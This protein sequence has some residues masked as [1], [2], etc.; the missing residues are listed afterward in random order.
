[1]GLTTLFHAKQTDGSVSFTDANINQQAIME[2][3]T[4]CFDE[5]EVSSTCDSV[6]FYHISNT[7]SM[8]DSE[9]DIETDTESD[10]DS[11]DDEDEE[12][13][14]IYHV[15]EDARRLKLAAKAFSNPEEKVNKY[16]GARCY[17]ER[18]SAPEVVS[19]DEADAQ[20]EVILDV[21]R[22]K[23]LAVDFLVADN[24]VKS[25]DPLSFGRNYFTSCVAADAKEADEVAQVLA[26]T[27][28]LKEQA[29]S[30]LCPEG[31]LKVKS[32]GA[33]CYFDR[34]SAP[35]VASKDE[36]DTEAEVLSD[37]TCMKGLAVD[38]LH[39]ESQTKSTDSFS[40]GRSYFVDPAECKE[41]AD[42]RAQILAEARLLK[43]QAT[44][45]HCPE[46]KV[47]VE[48]IGSRCYF[49][50]AS[51]PEP[52]TR[53]VVDA[54]SEIVLDASR[55]KKLA[56]GFLN[57]ENVSISITASSFGRN[58]FT[59]SAESKE[60]AD[61]RAEALAEAR[62]LKERATNYF[63]PE[64]KVTVESVGSRCYFERASAPETI[65]KGEADAIVE[66]LSDA[67]LIKKLSADFVHPENQ[68]NTTD[69]FSFGRNY[70]TKCSSVPTE[71]KEEVV[72]RAQFIDE[73]TLLKEHAT[74]YLCP[75]LVVTNTDPSTYGRNYFGRLD[76]NEVLSK[77]DADELYGIMSDTGVMKKASTDYL[78]PEVSVSNTHPFAMGRNYFK[79][80][81]SVPTETEEESNERFQILADSVMLKKA[82]VDYLQPEITSTTTDPTAYG[83][84]FFDNYPPEESRKESQLS[85]GNVSNADENNDYFVFDDFDEMREE[86][87]SFNVPKYPT[88][89]HKSFSTN[90]LYDLGTDDVEKERP[91][92]RSPSCVMLFG[93]GNL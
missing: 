32:F 35:E 88:N 52:V 72:K 91:V 47:N 38:F 48:S 44:K 1:M 85:Q 23:N 13:D 77:E 24:E 71:L 51:A 14:E 36:A 27:R 80:L 76:S 42:E 29:A 12:L 37:I 78:R 19:K 69:A 28:M 53:D 70:F 62:L 63:C 57:P 39:P 9:S 41:E 18:A 46:E 5:V 58:Y 3:H 64:K 45:Y 89:V 61:E 86:F 50:R 10:Y 82:A 7:G 93:L 83:R 84:N 54:Q 15:L 56:G 60:E 79:T 25:S 17:F 11:S 75:E 21:T 22:M 33:R 31:D 49:E 74:S 40:F 68:V 92:S 8:T 66:S 59:D 65:T 2:G 30:Y 16:F 90:R 26:E 73:A 4:D 55:M 20:A 81:S 67:T 43:E 6:G 34:A 87:N